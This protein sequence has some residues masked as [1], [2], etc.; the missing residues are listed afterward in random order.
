LKPGFA[1]SEQYF[2]KGKQGPW[3]D[4]Y[5]VA[6]TIYSAVTGVLPPEA[7]ER[8]EEDMLQP[9]SALGVSLPAG[10]D[11]ALMKALAMRGADRWQTMAS[12]RGSWQLLVRK[13]L[14]KL[15]I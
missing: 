4:V 11:A 14:L 2:S 1:P 5:A 9:A 10:A 7:M 15:K 8:V 12:F 13:K 3:T 6:A